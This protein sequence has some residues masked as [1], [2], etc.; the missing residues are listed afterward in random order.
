MADSRAKRIL[1]VDDE[2]DVTELVGYQL[3]AKGYAVEALNN[4]TQS[5]AKIRSFQPD[6]VI[7]DVMMPDI[8][9]IQICRMLRADPKTKDVPVVFLTAR[10][11]EADR[12]LGLEVGGDDYICKPFSSKE[13][14]LRIQGLLRRSVAPEEERPKR[15]EI[16][17]IVLD[18]ERHEAT[19]NG[20]P[21]ELTAT[22][23]R[24]LRLLMERKGRVQTREHLLLNVWNYETE[25][26]T[27]TVDTHIRRLREKLGDQA[28]LIETLRGVGYRMID[29]QANPRA[30]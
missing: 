13:L 7:L 25:I 5:I 8:S 29:P 2:P 9:G 30:C 11:E 10:A 14:L 12:V 20:L 6:L 3:R 26:E 27:R 22:E 4:P 21:I 15:L 24:L 1:I 16:G 23:F 19:V 17:S 18:N 28:D